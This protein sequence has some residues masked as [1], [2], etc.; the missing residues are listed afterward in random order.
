MQLLK[1]SVENFGVFKGMHTFDLS[2]SNENKS[3]PIII[4]GGLNGSGKTSLFE[5]FK[6]CIYGSLFRGHRFSQRHYETYLLGRVHLGAKLSKSRTSVSLEFYHSHLGKR[7]KYK[8]ERSWNTFTPLNEQLVVLQDGKPVP[9]VTEKQLQD[10]L[11]ELIPIGLS[12]LFFFDG[13]QIQNLAEDEKNNK[14]LIDAFNSL[15]SL[16]VVEHLQTDLKIYL[17]RQKNDENNKSNN[18]SQALSK[19]NEK[20][21]KKIEDLTQ[22]KGKSNLT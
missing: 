11:M 22:K 6:L 1:Y 5:G 19:E 18:E 20:V 15:L 7:S 9:G 13:E 3:K 2:T 10:F 16:D 17:V 4:I 21:Q 14:H 12:K 8:V